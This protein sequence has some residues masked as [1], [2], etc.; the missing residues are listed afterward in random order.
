MGAKGLIRTL[1]SGLRG[2]FKEASEAEI[3]KYAKQ[4]ES[5]MGAGLKK[6]LAQDSGSLSRILKEDVGNAS[7]GEYVD[8]A[9]SKGWASSESAF[10]DA[11]SMSSMA[12]A[13]P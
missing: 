1:K 13:S 8:G 2:V 10:S 7:I 12:H 6:E 3:Y 5:G 11:K 4:L 9:L